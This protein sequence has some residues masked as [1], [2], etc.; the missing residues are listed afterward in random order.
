MSKIN[1]TANR[2]QDHRKLSWIEHH[3]ETN[4]DVIG[5]PPS[6]V[7]R[8]GSV[9][10]LSVLVIILVLSYFIQVP[11]VVTAAAVVRPVKF[12]VIITSPSSGRVNASVRDGQWVETGAALFTVDGLSVSSPCRGKVA[13]LQ[14]GH[15]A[16]K[17][18]TI[19]AV[20][21]T[22]VV[23]FCGKLRVPAENVGKVRPGQEVAFA[24]PAFPSRQ[25]G[26]LKGRVQ[27]IAVLPVAGTYEVTVALPEGLITNAQY[28]IGHYLYLTGAASIVIAKR[29]LLA[30]IFRH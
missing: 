8:Y 19:A 5:K 6:K 2:E 23:I 16:E 29:S 30:R 1:H 4:V 25:Y 13:L 7:V 26:A 14:T 12:P 20:T 17:G 21:D 28:Q 27:N 15:P 11:E 18:D 24:L 22:G 10:I 9:L 3:P